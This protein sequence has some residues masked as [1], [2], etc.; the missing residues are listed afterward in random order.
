[1]TTRVLD[2]NGSWQ[3]KGINAYGT[4]PRDMR[5]VI[6]WMKATVPGTVH[7]DL[8]TEGVIPDPFHGMNEN[9]VQWVDSQK[10][11]YRRDFNVSVE[12]L[13]EKHIELVAEGL[14]TFA[15][16]RINR[17]IVAVTANMFI[18]HRID[19]KQYLHRGRNAIEICFD[20]PTRRSKALED[21]HGALR[22]AREPSRVYV[23]KAQYS[24]NWDWGPTLA[25]S[26]IWKNISLEAYSVPQLKNPFARVLSIHKQMAIVEISTDIEH[27]TRR[28]LNLRTYI[29][30]EGWSDS[31]VVQVKG[32]TATI[33][34]HIPNPRLWWPN[35]YGDQPL[36][37]AHLSL[38]DEERE[39][40][41][42][43]L[44]FAIRTVKLLQEKD[45]EGKSFV[46]E[47]N[48]VK[49]FCKGAD[50]IPCDSF[51]PRIP[52]STYERLLAFAKDAHMNMI[53][54]W[55]GGIYEQDLFYN[56]CDELGLMVW[57]D[58]M[59]ACGEYPQNGWFLDQVKAEALSV[60]R[61]LRNHPSVVV[62]CGNNECEWIFCTDNPGKSPDEMIGARIFRDILPAICKEHDGTRPYWRSSPFGTGFPN[63]EADGNHHQWM[64]WSFWKDYKEY[65]GDNGR[66]VTEFGFQAPANRRTFEEAL[67][68]R[69]CHPQSPA[70]EH[71]NK[72]VEGPERLIRFQAAHHRVSTDFDGFIYKCQLVQAEALKCAVEHWRRRKFK[73][74]G[75]LFWQL[76]DCWPVSS[77]AV[78]DSA[79]RPKASYYFTK[80]FYDPLLVSFKQADDNVEV[81]L[82]ND[83]LTTIS[84][85][86]KIA[87]RSFEGKRRWSKKRSVNV[88][89]NSS[90][91]LLTIGLEKFDCDKSTHYLHAQFL[92][93]DEVVTENRFFFEE[94]K[95]LRLRPGRVSLIVTKGKGARR[96]ISITADRFVKYLR[97]ELDDVVFDDNYFDLD[98]GVRRDITFNSHVPIKGIRKRMR[99]RW[100]E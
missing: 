97:L 47:V 53:R 1:M 46:V 22:V 18:A 78:I 54:V 89:A 86:L 45:D 62:W 75:A 9:L 28:A 16:I 71:H 42:T 52:D 100:L 8:M 74:A 14:D 73:T 30:Y 29:G 33:Q 49:M 2:L 37:K 21:L 80:K 76:N 7:T 67:L 13:Q 88:P 55:G 15:E 4:M 17:K 79:L 83:H 65:E 96:R 19:I 66:F 95:R 99:L 25:T 40:D 43:E 26:G 5:R 69:D 41:S 70:F 51:L 31:S 85:T 34:I 3:F 27:A 68:P 35:G 81:H 82:T 87:L 10:W 11:V 84:G 50:W 63:G 60:V 72:Q 32:T 94:P 24:F 77:W 98:P 57:Q 44:P 56:L 20:S 92:I 6:Q 58:F 23:R 38:F 39:L 36:Y 12:M 93:D 59:F 90:K 48:G 91:L 61:R 64:V